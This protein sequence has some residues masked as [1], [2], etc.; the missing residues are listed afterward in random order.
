MSSRDMVIYSSTDQEEKDGSGV[1][2]AS[3]P[4]VA[5]K[6]PSMFNVVLL[7]DDFTPMDFVI[8]VLVEVFKKSPAKATE[9]MMNVHKKGKGVAGT[10]TLDVAETKHHIVQ[11]QAQARQFPLRSIVER[12]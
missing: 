3:K 4:E 10:Y 6:R 9:V 8:E 1:A 7:N 5:V 11:E 12:A 2:I